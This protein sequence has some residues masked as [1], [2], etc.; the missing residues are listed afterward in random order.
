MREWV[1]AQIGQPRAQYAE[2]YFWVETL[3]IFVRFLN[4][5]IVLKY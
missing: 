3:Y 2:E 5:V 4:S 1:G